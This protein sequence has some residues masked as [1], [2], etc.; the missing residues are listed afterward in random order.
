MP[1]SSVAFDHRR[2]PRVNP[3]P[4]PFNHTKPTRATRRKRHR[5]G[6]EMVIKTDNE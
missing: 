3:P 1:R 2:E 6:N 4:E 5:N